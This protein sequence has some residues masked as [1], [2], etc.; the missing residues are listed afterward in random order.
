MLRLFQNSLGNRNIFVSAGKITK[1]R[2]FPYEIST[3]GFV[4][5]RR[6]LLVFL[7]T[8]DYKTLWYDDRLDILTFGSGGKTKNAYSKLTLAKTTIHLM[9]WLV[10]KTVGMS[11]IAVNLLISAN[12]AVKSITIDSGCENLMICYSFIITQP[13]MSICIYK[14]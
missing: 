1:R 10:E 4:D 7:L 8:T 11:F 3:L 2:S 9:K 12:L 13:S 6:L 5:A 14:R